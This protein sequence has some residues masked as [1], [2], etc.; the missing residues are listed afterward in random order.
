MRTRGGISFKQI[1]LREYDIPDL[2]LSR[3]SLFISSFVQSLQSH[4]IQV[5]DLRLDL[6]KS[7]K[8][9]RIALGL[10][11]VWLVETHKIVPKHSREADTDHQMCLF[12]GIRFAKLVHK[13]IDLAGEAGSKVEHRATPEFA[14]WKCSQIETGHDA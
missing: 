14:L 5:I 2:G 6:G 4:C 3:L 12:A 8:Y 13:S 7:V 10:Q 1:W 9:R 11:I